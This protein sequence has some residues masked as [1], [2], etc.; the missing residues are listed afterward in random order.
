MS[1][2]EKDLVWLHGAIRT[3]PFSTEARIEAGVLLRRLQLGEEAL[4]AT[5]P[6]NAFDRGWMS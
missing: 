1:K 4:T 3:P 5:L 6:A 2:A